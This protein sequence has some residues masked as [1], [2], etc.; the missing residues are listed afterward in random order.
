[1]NPSSVTDNFSSALLMYIGSTYFN[2]SI[3]VSKE[4]LSFSNVSSENFVFMSSMT[5]RSS[6]SSKSSDNSTT[7]FSG[8]SVSCC[9]GIKSNETEGLILRSK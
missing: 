4:D 6:K 9:E 7:W 1:M 3:N 2:L 8:W 5:S